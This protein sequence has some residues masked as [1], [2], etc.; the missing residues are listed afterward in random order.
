[1]TAESDVCVIGAGICGISTVKHCLEY[2]LSVTC[3]EQRSALGGLW[4][5]TSPD[6]PQVGDDGTLQVAVYQSI[7]MNVS[8]I[9]SS[10]SDFPLPESL[11]KNVDL[12]DRFL[13]GAQLLEYINLYVRHFKVDRHIQLST[14]V[15]DITKLKSVDEKDH[16]WEVTVQQKVGEKDLIRTTRHRYV[17]LASG[18]HSEAFIPKVID[19]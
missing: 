12:E 10:F 17:V 11:L 2:G 4:T 5:G 9:L 7:V 6:V 13:S 1:M 3:Y 18:Y 14:R 16:R 15:L 8:R 19:F